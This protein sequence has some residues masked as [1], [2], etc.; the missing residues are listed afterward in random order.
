MPGRDLLTYTDPRNKQLQQAQQQARQQAQQ[1]QQQQKKEI[2][3]GYIKATRYAEAA[4]GNYKV[5]EADG[6]YIEDP[7]L[8]RQDGEIYVKEGTGKPA[9]GSTEFIESFLGGESYKRASEIADQKRQE[10]S[11]QRSRERTTATGAGFD[12]SGIA[13]EK[14]K[15]ERISLDQC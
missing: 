9:S 7:E 2:P 6:R 5:V 15:E 1:Q 12:P 13:S 14:V 10:K 8:L 4:G 3:T 11:E